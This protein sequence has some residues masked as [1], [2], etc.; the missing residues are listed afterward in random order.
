MNVR[1]ETSFNWTAGVY[2]E[3]LMLMNNYTVT[4]YMVTNTADAA[5]QNV[6]YERLKHFVYGEMANTIYVNREHVDQCQKYLA[7]GLKITTLP[8]EP[9]DQLL[10]LML[11]C[12]LNAIMQDHIIINEVE[13]SS[14]LGERMI[15][16]HSADENLG[17]F[18]QAGWWHSDD[19]I[20]C[21]PEIMDTEK[22]VNL[23]RISTWRD[24]NLAWNAKDDSE[25]VN[26]DN[27]VVFAEFRKD[28]TK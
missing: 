4:L 6:A 9:V 10:G 2:W 15:Y 26:Q 22:I 5:T 3:G 14:N 7:A 23:P 12:K 13:I 1:L 16:L 11:Y 20:H 18:E 17:P 25:P 19:L 28:E 27:T 24:L 21:D 8:S